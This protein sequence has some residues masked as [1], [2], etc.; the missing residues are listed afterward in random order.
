MSNERNGNA[1]A[2]TCVSCLAALP[3]KITAAETLCLAQKTDWRLL[4]MTGSGRTAPV[5]GESL[6]SHWKVPRPD[7]DGKQF[8]RNVITTARPLITLIRKSRKIQRTARS[9]NSRGIAGHHPQRLKIAL[10]F[11]NAGRSGIAVEFGSFDEYHGAFVD[12]GGEKKKWSPV[13][14]VHLYLTR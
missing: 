9:S 13:P 7:S 3:A 2:I 1:L 8:S 14:A 6:S 11:R 10:R 5:I 12:N 4:I